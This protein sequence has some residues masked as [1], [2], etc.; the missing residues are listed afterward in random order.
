MPDYWAAVHY[1]ERSEKLAVHCI[2][3]AANSSVSAV[4]NWAFQQEL[5]D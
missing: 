4:R 5:A 3:H 2:D 1:I